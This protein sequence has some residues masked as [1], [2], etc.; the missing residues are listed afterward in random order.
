M[1]QRGPRLFK[2]SKATPK[3]WRDTL[4]V[5]DLC[6][7]GRGL[8]RRGGKAV[9][10]RG[11][12]TGERVDARSERIGGRYDEALAKT[13]LSPAPERVEPRCRHYAHCGGCQLQHLGENAQR[14]HKSQRFAAMISRLGVDAACIKP[15]LTGQS[16]H[17]RHRLRLHFALNKGRIELG[18]RASKSHQITEVP[19][20]QVLRPAL[21]AALA[22]LYEHS[23]PLQPL[24]AGMLMLAESEG[25]GVSAHLALDRRPSQTVLKEFLS[26]FAVAHDAISLAAVSVAGETLWEAEPEHLSAGLYPGQSWRFRPDDFT[27]VN[28]NIN[29]AIVHQVC[30]WLA[31]DTDDQVLDAFAGLGNFS[32]ALAES[33]VTITGVEADAGMVQRAADNAQ[34]WP[35]LRFIQ[36]DLFSDAYRLPANINKLVLDPPRAGAAS[37]CKVLAGRALERVVYVSCDPA[38]LERDAAILLAGGYAL[39]EARWADMFPQS[40]HMESL[41]LFVPN[42]LS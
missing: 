20:C 4:D 10:V 21:S 35:R 2:P 8:A 26:R 11:A 31:A 7:D 9:F 30:H 38:T 32:L 27:Q 29:A 34:S 42:L 19:D 3:P 23:A 16:W 37:L 40:Y 5:V 13:I 1:K 36:G 22:Q 12:L 24:R 6:D 28:P 39:S 17:Y 25:G 14:A 18:F 33:G 15:P 41:C